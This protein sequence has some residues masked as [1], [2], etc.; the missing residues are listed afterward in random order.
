VTGAVLQFL[1]ILAYLII[2]LISV[3]F[4]VYAIAITYLPREKWESEKEKTRR[5]E[6]LKVR[7]TSLTNELK[8]EAKDSVKVDQIKEQLSRYKNE[9]RGTQLGIR[10]LTARGAVAEPVISLLFALLIT[11]VGIF[12]YYEANTNGGIGCAFLSCIILIWGVYRL[13]KTITAIEL[14]ALRP[15]RTVDFAIGFGEKK[16]TH[17]EIKL[18]KLTPLRIACVTEDCYVENFCMCGIFPKELE[19][20]GTSKGNIIIV[21]LLEYSTV[22][23]ETTFLPRN[24]HGAFEGPVKPNK[25][26]TFEIQIFVSG[27]GISENF[28]T[29]TVEVV[30]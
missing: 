27:K 29:L 1:L 18:G 21:H 2:G 11:A 7:I 17:A 13:Y 12:F 24:V 28:K 14:T 8:G 9:L 10:Y 5:I 6:K 4:P 25:V 30:K 23:Y 22:L 3:T 19:V 20:V 15:A 16:A 26:G